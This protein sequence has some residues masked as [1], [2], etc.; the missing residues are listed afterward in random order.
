MLPPE[1]IEDGGPHGGGEKDNRE[2][3][4]ASLQPCPLGA[5]SDLSAQ[6]Q[7]SARPGLQCVGCSPG[8]A[9]LSKG[10]KK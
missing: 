10:P 9:E 4:E 6:C 3:L 1:Q 8:E 7:A 2:S 5:R